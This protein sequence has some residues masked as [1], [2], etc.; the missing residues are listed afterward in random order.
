M[1]FEKIRKASELIR[2][3][4]KT[5]VLTG[6]GISTESGI[7]DF[8][9]P[10]TGLWEN[11]DPMEVLSTTVLYNEPERFYKEGFNILLGM[12]D[13]NP[14]KGHNILAEME[15]LGFIDGIITQ[16][17]DNLHH[18]AG[19]NYILEVH[20]NTREAFCMNCGHTVD[21]NILTGKVNNNE[22]PPK[23]NICGGILRPDVI[24]FGD[25]L[26]DAFNI[27]FREVE[28]SNLLIVIG[29]SLMVAPVN[30]LPQIANKLII[31]NKGYTVMDDFAEVKIEGSAGDVLEAILDELE[32]N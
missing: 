24:L 10:G 2:N 16:N 12:M 21:I 30:Y 5:M 26:P 11:T 22:I 15:S 29:S 17:I 4:N 6:A 23:C 27:A 28:N 1:N 18:K 9:S 32:G 7:P 19:S 13:A 25:M 20:G 3:S 31:I 14:N 8:R